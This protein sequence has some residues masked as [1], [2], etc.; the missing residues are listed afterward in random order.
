MNTTSKLTTSIET[1]EWFMLAIKH[2]RLVIDLHSTHGEVENGLHHGHVE[3]II[4]VH[5]HVMEV[6]L[7][8]LGICRILQLA[9]C[10]GVVGLEGF[11]QCLFAA[12]HLLSELSSRHL[13]HETTAR[14]VPGVKVKNVGRFRIQDESDGPAAFLLFS[15][16]SIR[17]VVAM[18]EIVCESLA[19][20][21]QQDPA[22]ASKSL[23]SQKF[24]F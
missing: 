1:V 18:S 6:F 2:L 10:D 14:V 24:P 17:H 13:L 21:V 12:A 22:F 15:P 9:L 23:G 7:W 3:S 8:V 19:F 16:H 5:G 20:V 4:D 11:V